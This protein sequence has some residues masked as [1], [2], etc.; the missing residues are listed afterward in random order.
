MSAFHDIYDPPPAPVALAPRR[1]EP[2][3]FTR[4]DLACLLTLCTLLCVAAG[5][6]WPGEPG[7]A[8]VSALGGSLVVLESWFT[9]LGLLHKAGALGLRARWSVFLA[10]LLPWIFGLG[11]AAMLILGLFWITDRLT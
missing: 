10:A 8:V 9:A 11:M 2:L 6:A 3:S 1:D 4:G 5:L 7:M